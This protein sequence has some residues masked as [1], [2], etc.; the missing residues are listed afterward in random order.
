MAIPSLIIVGQNSPPEYAIIIGIL[1]A[2]FLLIASISAYG[3]PPPL[4]TIER[5]IHE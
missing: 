4:I 1:F 5:A 3:V 2:T